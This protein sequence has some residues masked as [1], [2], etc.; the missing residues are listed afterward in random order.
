MRLRSAVAVLCLVLLWLAPAS[1]I[2]I[3]GKP[4]RNLSPPT[5]EFA[6]RGWDF[7]GKW[8]GFLGTPIAPHY[9]VTAKHIGGQIGQK[10]LYR[11]KAYEA[12]ESLPCPDND[13]AVWRVKE[14]F[15]AWA[16]LYTRDQE[17]D[18]PIFVTGCGTARGAPL[19]DKEGRL[20]GWRWG[21]DDHRQSW[22]TNRAAGISNYTA[23]K[24]TWKNE[25]VLF[26]FDESGPAS[27]G[28]VS[29]SDSGGA[30]FVRDTDGIWKLAGIIYGV[31]G[32]PFSTTEDGKD[33][34]G[35]ALLDAR[36]LYEKVR[37]TGEMHYHDPLRAEPE[38]TTAGA[39]RISSSL[40][41][42]YSVVPELRPF[43][44]VKTALAGG[45]GLLAALLLL[46]N[47]HQVQKRKRRV[48]GAGTYP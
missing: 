19:I 35:A 45:A 3:K 12:V 26:A 42:I 37:G 24:A 39:T 7:T 48:N 1:A 4:G 30:V 22:G 38:P 20:R 14:T 6:G 16:P 27:E 8:G 33:A 32:T 21:A 11:G 5:G 31:D 18:K 17:M 46:A 25:M 15:P 29:G 47:R 23:P 41:F 2:I 34:S 43:P 36:G 10:L 44:L 13:L 9:F 28:I 40:P